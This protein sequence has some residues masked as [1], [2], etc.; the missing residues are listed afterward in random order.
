MIVK[1]K[2]QYLNYFSYVIL[3]D[4]LKLL[5]LKQLCSVWILVAQLQLPMLIAAYVMRPAL[6]IF[7]SLVPF[8][9]PLTCFLHLP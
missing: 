1:M 8:P 7:P 3:C 4:Y 9:T 2:K 6:A 5:Y